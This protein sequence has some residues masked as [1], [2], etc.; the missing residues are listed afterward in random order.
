MEI[1]IT[2]I[3]DIGQ[4]IDGTDAYV[5]LTRK[6][7]DLTPDEAVEWLHPKVYR[8]CGGPGGYFCNTVLATQAPYSTNEVICI[9]QHRYDV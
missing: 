2:K 9:I 1:T 5:L 6:D 4:G 8:E 3:G 7:D